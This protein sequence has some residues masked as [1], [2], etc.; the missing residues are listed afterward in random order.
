VPPARKYAPRS[1]IT[2]AANGMSKILVK[3]M[4]MMFEISRFVS[5][6][7]LNVSEILDETRDVATCNPMNATRNITAAKNVDAP[8]TSAT[9]L[10]KLP[11]EMLEVKGRSIVKPRNPI[12][13]VVRILLSRALIWALCII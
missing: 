11:G 4:N 6:S 3:H 2:A 13:I 5:G 9:S 10:G 1:T 7:G 8:P 12:S